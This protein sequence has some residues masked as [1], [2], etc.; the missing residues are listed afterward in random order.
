MTMTNE[1]LENKIRGIAYFMMN[2]MNS[3]RDW[4]IEG[5]RQLSYG[6]DAEIVSRYESR[7]DLSNRVYYI[8]GRAIQAGLGY[9]VLLDNFSEL[10]NVDLSEYAQYVT[11]P[12]S[13]YPENEESEDESDVS[14]GYK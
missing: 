6:D 8:N 11:I 12:D 14:G 3:W 1:D 5:E 2:E 10:L 7:E 9:G 13:I 4:V